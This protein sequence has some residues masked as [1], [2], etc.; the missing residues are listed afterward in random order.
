MNEADQSQEVNR[1]QTPIPQVIQDKIDACV[2]NADDLL[3]SAKRVLEGER[4]PNIA[5]HLATLA[6]EEIGKAELIGMSHL[7]REQAD[8]L[9]WAERHEDH[10]R[11]LFWALWGPSFGKEIITREQIESFQRLARIIHSTRLKGLYVDPSAQGPLPKDAVAEEETR[12]LISLATARL[13]IEK[14]QGPRALDQKGQEV[15]S[16][17]LT[18]TKDPEKRNLIFGKKSMERLAELGGTRQWMEWLKQE[19]EKAE[20][21]ARALAEAELRRTEPA[22]SEAAKEKW[23]LR[24]RI[25][26]NSHSIRPRP[27]HDWNKD[28][29]WIKL[30]P[31]NNKKNEIL[32]E[33]IL[34]KNIPVHALW[35]AGWGIARKFVVSMNIGSLG[36]FWWYVPQQIS[37]FYEGLKDLEAEAN[38][39]VERSPILK[40]DWKRD[41]LTERDLS[42][43]KLC[44]AMIPSPGG[45][46]GHE[47]FDH[48]ITGL[49]FLSKTDIHMQLEANAYEAFYKAL[50]TAMR[51]YRDWDGSASFSQVFHAVMKDLIP[52]QTD[53]QRFIDLGEQ[54]EKK[55]V[56]VSQAITLSETGG[57]KILCD[58]YFLRTFRRLADERAKLEAVHSV[59]ENGP[60]KN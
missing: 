37:R 44:F 1:S 43:V 41:A 56:A 29:T 28:I 51:V 45:E 24:I 33:F 55:P 16:W 32:V 58:A 20:R 52:E 2:S 12:N 27:L 40:L 18:A 48:Y 30:L 31:V 53:R 4:L 35:W 60:E 6:L 36:Y 14:T 50:K 15:F 26:T 8:P 57:I 46:G 47:P 21:E 17:F 7:A 59:P 23:K 42:N 10:V 3:R 13:G 9:E 49:A 25:Y 38:V 34:P 11:K 39:V 19:F 5:Y 22:A 54:F